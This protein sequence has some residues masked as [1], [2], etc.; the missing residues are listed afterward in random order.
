MRF[1]CST[2]FTLLFLIVSVASAQESAD[3][4]P[5]FTK[6]IVPF[7]HAHC[8]ACHGGEEPEGGLRLDKYKTNSN[9]QTD[10]ERWQIIR[11]MVNESQMPP[12]DEEQPTG[13]QVQQFVAA[14]DEEL[15]TFDCSAVKRPGR[16]TLQRL[17]R[18]EYNN[19][20]RDLVGLDLSLADD[21][22]SDDVGEGFDNIGDVLT[23]PP[24]L[25]EKYLAAAQTIAEKA[26]KD[27]TARKTIFVREAEKI[28]DKIA[29]ARENIEQ[30]AERAFRRPIEPDQLERL[31]DIM[32][33]AYEQGADDDEIYSTVVTAVLVSPRFLFRVEKDPRPNDPDGIRDL[34]D[35]ELAS[36]LSYFLWSSMPDETLLELARAGQLTRP[37]VIAEQARRMLADPKATALVENFAGQWLQLRDVTRLAPDPDLF[38]NVNPQLQADMRRE[39]EA[40]F[41]DIMR[42]NRSVLSLLDADYTFL[43]KRLAQHYG[44]DGVDGEQFQR[45][46]LNGNRRGILTHASILMLTSNPNRTSPVKRGKWILENILGEPPPPPPPNVPELKDEGETLGSLREQM[47]QH[48]A[49]PSCAVC[50]QKMDTLG[51]G[52]ENFDAVGA[53]RDKDGRFDIDATG[54]LPGNR[55]FSG[56]VELIG[57]LVDEKKTEFCRTM[58]RKMLTYALGRGLESFDRCTVKGIV[59][60][61][62]KDDYRFGTLVEAIVQ[63]DAFRQRE[64]KMN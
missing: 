26:V 9:V 27:K 58:T 33:F 2:T 64:G 25:L 18:V 34:D 28:E 51:F 7:L 19:T 6:T 47:Q 37:K 11:R 41:E 24:I 3:R 59:E 16:V 56:P 30:F 17:N 35:F 36:R 46:A 29:A 38:S 45:V 39:T 1:L 60:Q 10:Y 5:G 43:N 22:P 55:H 20:I 15:A 23:L 40:V 14:I 48:R 31:F 21:F 4:A 42:N 57:I 13:E 50:H 12:A 54:T 44:I 8:T 49:N 62:A 61:L 53:W 52:L 63:S 32:K